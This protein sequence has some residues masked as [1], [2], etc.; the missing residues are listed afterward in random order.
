MTPTSLWHPRHRCCALFCTSYLGGRDI[1]REKKEQP[2]LYPW[3]LI[4]REIAL[5][6]HDWLGLS[7]PSLGEQHNKTGARRGNESAILHPINNT[8]SQLNVLSCKM[9]RSVLGGAAITQMHG[10]DVWHNGETWVCSITW[11]LPWI[12]AFVCK[13]FWGKKGI[14]KFCRF[15]KCIIEQGACL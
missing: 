13:L 14:Y 12:R 3:Q 5:V 4:T 7:F 8:F 2:S 15:L 6:W 9:G 1:Q 11:V 10:A